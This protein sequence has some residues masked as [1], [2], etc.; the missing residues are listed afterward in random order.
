MVLSYALISALILCCG[1]LCYRWVMADE[2]QHSYNRVLLYVIYLASLLIPFFI[3]ANGMNADD[4]LQSATIKF[5]ELTAVGIKSE[6]VVNNAG[7]WVSLS[8][9]AQILVI[10]YLVGVGAMIMV[11]LSGLIAL[12]RVIR[13]G[14][15]IPEGKYAVVI[16][17]NSRLAPFSWMRYIVMTSADYAETGNVI[18]E[19]ELCHLRLRHWI[20]L[21]FAQAVIC[22]Q[23]FNPAAWLMREELRTVHEYQADDAVIKSGAD[24]SGY[25]KMLIKKAVGSRFQS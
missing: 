18:M 5:G 8:K 17:D 23:W 3:L 12:W 16:T 10:I 24:M 9:V 25:Q 4:S 11:S 1:Y 19:H 21:M 14:E 2:C 22:L 13:K 20:D 6:A 15:K 7:Q